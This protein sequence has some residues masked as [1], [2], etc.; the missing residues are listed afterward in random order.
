MYI[1]MIIYVYTY[2][3][4]A[5]V[6]IFIATLRKINISI[7][8]KIYIAIYLCLIATS[9]MDHVSTNPHLEPADTWARIAHPPP[10]DWLENQRCG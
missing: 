3:V 7:D 2:H 4:H 8:Q 6:P 9:S 5:H 10:Q 1:Y